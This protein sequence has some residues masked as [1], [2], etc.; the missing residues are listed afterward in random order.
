[1]Q[2]NPMNNQEA[3]NNVN[4]MSQETVLGTETK[5]S[6]F[7][8]NILMQQALLSEQNTP[9]ATLYIVG[10][11]IGNA[12]DITL[13]ALWMLDLVDV[14]ACEDTRQ[15][16]KLLD[17]YGIHTP[18]MSVHEHNERS[19]SQVVIQALDAGKRVA[20]V[21]DAGTPAVSDPGARCVDAVRSAGF[22]V[23]PVPGASAVVTAISASGLDSYQFTFAGFIPAQSK[24]RRTELVRLADRSEA[25]V[26]YEAPH[27]LRELLLDLADQLDA[28]RRVVVARELTKK[29]ETLV[30]MP[31]ADLGAWAKEHEPRGEYVIVVDMKAQKDEGLSERD[32]A[33]ARALAK[34]VPLSR[35]AAITA[36]ITGV[37]RDVVYQRLSAEKSTE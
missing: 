13:R 7:A 20:L 14:I 9:L 37:K 23:I 3:K 17:R 19:A 6:R 36:K 4:D 10:L 28:D 26:L 8:D 27:R 34:E 5:L 29:F 21:T 32:L 18:T 24:A 25:F 33:W 12:S 11:P 31:A 30:A 22:R 16:R 15:T 35:A 2:T 1:M